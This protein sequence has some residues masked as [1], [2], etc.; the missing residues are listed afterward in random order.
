MRISTAIAVSAL[1]L[2]FSAW[3][4]E[5]RATDHRTMTRSSAMPREEASTMQIRL[6]I[7][8]KAMTATLADNATA[9]D[10]V[11]LLPLTLTLEDYASTEKIAYLPRKL[12]T[13]G[14]PAG[15]DPDVGDIT[16]YAP[17]GN[18]AIFHRDFGYSTGLIKLGR[19]DG[20]VG[21]LATRGPVKVTIEMMRQ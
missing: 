5:D 1:A 15:M 2:A 12:S 16:Y 7:D 3:A 21:A 4:A 14:A 9:R 17:W 19:L 18:L 10:L 13:A 11:A 6:I 8:G 20:G